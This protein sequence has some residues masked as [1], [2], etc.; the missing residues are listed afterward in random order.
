MVPQDWNLGSILIYWLPMHK[1]IT[2]RIMSALR[3]KLITCLNMPAPNASAKASPY[4]LVI[5]YKPQ[6][7]KRTQN[8]TYLMNMATRR[9]LE[10]VNEP[11]AKHLSR[12]LLNDLPPPQN[13]AQHMRR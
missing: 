12:P 10:P 13:N 3:P 2:H 9:Y 5:W 8:Y 4:S 1:W 6:W 11:L 7:T